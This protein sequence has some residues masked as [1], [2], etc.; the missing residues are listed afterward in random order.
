VVRV[1][2]AVAVGLEERAAVVAAAVRVVGAVPGA[3]VAGAVE[4]GAAARAVV[5]RAEVG[6]PTIVVVVI[7]RGVSSSRT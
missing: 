7:V 4:A 6:A 1:A 3:A 5:P 2:S